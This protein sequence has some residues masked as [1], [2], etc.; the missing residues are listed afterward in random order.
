MKKAQAPNLKND[1]S[2]EK[3]HRSKAGHLNVSR[4]REFQTEVGIQQAAASL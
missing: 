4:A 3:Y 1:T 2:F